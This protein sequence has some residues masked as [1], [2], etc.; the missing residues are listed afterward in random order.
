M[1]LETLLHK[2]YFPK[3]LPPPFTT[4]KFA[5]KITD[6][7]NAWD[8]IFSSNTDLSGSVGLTRTASET[9]Q[10]FGKRKKAK[11]KEFIELHSSSDSLNFSLAKGEWARRVLKIPNPKHFTHLSAQIADNWSTLNDIYSLS[12]FSKSKPIPDGTKRSVKTFSPTVSSFREALIS[13]SYDSLFE[14]RVDI[15]KFYPT[16][17]THSITWAIL[18]KSKAKEYFLKKGQLSFTDWAALLATDADAAAYDLANR[19]D[20]SVR[21]CQLRQ[22]IGIPIGPDTSHII[23]ELIACRI[24]KL[25]KEKFNNV[26]KGCRYYDDYYLYLPS[27]AESEKVLKE[28][29]KILNEFQ[30]E[31]N[32]AKL[33]IDE[34]PF[35]FE[36]QWVI[37]LNQFQF[38]GGQ[39][40]NIKQYFSMAFG[41]AHENQ[42]RA[43]WILRY[44]LRV[45]EWRSVEIE[46]NSWEVFESLLLKTALSEPATLEEVA[47]ILITYKGFIG[48]ASK[49]RISNVMKKLLSE[50]SSINHSFEMTWAIWI[51][52]AFELELNQSTAQ[53][54]INTKDPISNLVLL[55]LNNK[56]L[57]K[58]SV[59]FAPLNS[60]LTTESLYGEHWLFTYEAVKKGWLSPSVPTLLDDHDYFKIL[61]DE[62]I[63]FYE[64]NKEI[65][66]YPSKTQEPKEVATEA[67]EGE[68][69]TTETT[70]VSTGLAFATDGPSALI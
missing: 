10:A 54:V 62:N 67:A 70:E 64:L 11:K 29:Q 58:G 46:E 63:E 61:K 24:D 47:R 15:S 14:L 60:L 8:A 53:K 40:N 33:K 17:Y 36:N 4:E 51:L 35:S 22:S 43:D 6:V 32:E 23:S 37:S 42:S 52:R 5:N 68:D 27:K 21:A 9:P 50:H 39:R 12:N 19:I 7:K 48:T 31:M 34:F 2:G 69:S 59:D 65:Y 25:L 26:L 55:D 66:T 30:L 56:G 57:V 3:E 13:T 49:N 38:S 41:F 45:F 16:I 18:G 1:N 28:L 44:F 20:S